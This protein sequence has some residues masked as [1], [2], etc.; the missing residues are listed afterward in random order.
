MKPD[1]WQQV[2]TVVAGALDLPPEERARF[3][4]SA[5]KTDGELRTEVESLLRS[6]GEAKGFLESQTEIRVPD[7][8]G[9][10]DPRIGGFVG[11]YRITDRIGSGGMG[12]VYRADDFRL[13]RPAALKFLNATLERDPTAC[14]RFEVEARAASAL[15]HPNICTIYGV[16]EFEGSPFLAMELLKGM[17]LS[18]VIQGKPMALLRVIELGT[19]IL[20]AL[21]AAHAEGIVH[22]DLKPANVFVTDKGQVK[23]LDFGLAKRTPVD[24]VSSA[25][26][27]STLSLDST[28]ITN[29]GMIVGTVSYM[30]PEQIRAEDVDSRSDL[31]SFG[32]L[33][34]EMST[35]EKA[36][37][38]KLPVLVL[39]AILNRAPVPLEQSNP[40]IPARFAAIISKALEKDRNRRYQSAAELS[41]DLLAF[42]QSSA[43]DP[44]PQ[45]RHRF[46]WTRSWLAAG[47]LITIL[48]GTTAG[49]YW[50]RHSGTASLFAARPV[51]DAPRISRPA[52][53]VFGFENLAGRP[54]QAWLSTAFSEALSTELAAGGRMRVVSGEDVARVKKDLNLGQAEAYSLATLSRIRKNLG[55]DYIVTGS[56]LATGPE[57]AGQL[58]LDA[59][60]QDARTGELVAS[61]PETGTESQLIDLLSR[62]GADLRTKLGIGDVSGADVTKVAAIIPRNPDAARLYSE[63]LARLRELDPGEA[64]TLLLKAVGIEPDHPLIHAALAEAWGQLGYDEKAQTEA[65]K[66]ASLAGQLPQ[67]E[68]LWVE[69]RFRESTHD[70]DRAIE[71]YRTLVGFY[72]DNI[73][74]GLRLASAQ[75]NAGRQKDAVATIA[76]LRKLPSPASN[77]PRIDL[78]EADAD[79]ISAD[80]KHESTVAARALEEARNRGARLLAA[81]AQYAQAWAALNMG[82]MSDAVKFAEEARA[83]YVSAG[84]RNGEAN[85]LRTLGTVHLMQGDLSAALKFYEDSLRLAN[86]VGNRYSEAAALN[87]IATTLYRQGKHDEA[88]D[89]Y[90]KALAIVREVGNKAAEATA[91]N[92][93]ANIFWAKGDLT[94]ARDSY[95]QAV[96]IA[97]QLG[98]RGREAGST[99]NI[100]HILFQKGDI[101]GAQQQINK[102][103]PLASAIGEAD[104]LAEAAN[105]SGD[106]FLAGAN[107]SAADG[108]FKE[109]MSLRESQGDQLGRDESRISIAELRLAENKPEEAEK[110]LYAALDSSRKTNAQE[111]EIVASGV[112]ARALLQHGKLQDA[113][114]VVN[115]VRSRAGNLQNPYVRSNFLIEASRV[116]ARSGRVAEANSALNS[117]LRIANSNQFAITQLKARLAL[118]EIE[119]DRAGAAKADASFETVQRDAQAQGFLLIASQAAAMRTKPL[120]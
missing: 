113:L 28:N 60:L 3:L 109:A 22:R 54:E 6:A 91:V 23:I 31:F 76:A 115:V 18:E 80:F 12:V 97:R 119:R 73:E 7:G 75:T 2:R 5:C 49:V 43:S 95:E 63:G 53:A 39:D 62:S 87:Q 48:I 66:A 89:R 78:A 81:R 46:G 20:S 56:Y 44:V 70:W 4:D 92:N 42:Q 35:G 67:S 104:I 58:R 8:T 112:L 117:V 120:S 90:Q 55:V 57:A 33:L 29:A 116:D 65:Q 107:F 27:A 11:T 47:V 38:G 111:N 37:P 106:I 114:R 86:Q 40:Q 84:D 45:P 64:R 101:A 41:N 83:V 52:I 13:G 96:T 105:A 108:K 72:P 50:I 85:L 93:I 94:S 102:A 25:Y 82:N 30:S 21:D 61:L 26:L 110:I 51:P 98:D 10:S 14:E 77:D 79:E 99:V 9:I 68:Q 36:F 17:T 16:D 24:T 69:G 59:R 71:V 15:N 34:Y 88:L 32:A 103:V 19:Q 118:A 1:R 100:A 74:Y